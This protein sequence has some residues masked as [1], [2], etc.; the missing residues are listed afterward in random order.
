MIRENKYSGFCAWHGGW[1]AAGKGFA[2]PPGDAPDW[3]S[4][5]DSRWTLLCHDCGRLAI[6]NQNGGMDPGMGG[7]ATA[8]PA[9][10]SATA[11]PASEVPEPDPFRYPGRMYHYHEDDSAADSV[12]TP[13]GSDGSA[14]HASTDGLPPDPGPARTGPASSDLTRAELFAEI[15]R[16]HAE[17]S[18]AREQANRFRDQASHS[19][20]AHVR[21]KARVEVLAGERNRFFNEVRAANKRASE[22]SAAADDARL[23]RD[24]VIRDRQAQ[25]ERADRYARRLRDRGFEP[26]AESPGETKERHDREERERKSRPGGG[27]GGYAG[28]GGPSGSGPNPGGSAG[29]SGSGGFDPFADLFGSGFGFSGGFRWE[30]GSGPDPFGRPGGSRSGPGGSSPAGGPTITPPPAMAFLGLPEGATPA[31]VKSAYRTRCKTAHPDKGG[32]AGEFNRLREAYEAALRY[33]ER[34]RR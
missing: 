29:P 2:I 31:E 21:L 32:T 20:A 6:D 23:V 30:P 18:A 3:I 13:A 24:A 27:P 7:P 28:P 33:A 16:L 34:A 22:A 9:N 14:A 5:A 12:A 25:R 17:L 26:E 1:V 4:Q 8:K 15:S 10:G 11:K 19:E